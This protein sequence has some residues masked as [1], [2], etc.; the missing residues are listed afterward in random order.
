MDPETQLDA[1]W[2]VGIRHRML[3]AG[4]PTVAIALLKQAACNDRLNLSR[5]R[6]SGSLLIWDFPYP[7]VPK[8]PLPL[9]GRVYSG[10]GVVQRIKPFTKRWH[11]FL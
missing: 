1:L 8:G 9:F 11:N 4:L 2:N 10:S 3:S 7:K 5:H 6:C